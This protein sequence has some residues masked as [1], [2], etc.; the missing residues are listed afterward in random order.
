MAPQV[1]N[2]I[3]FEEVLTGAGNTAAES[4]VQPA[5]DGM[6]H[7]IA[8]PTFSG[9]DETNVCTVLHHWVLVQGTKAQSATYLFH[10][11]THSSLL[12]LPPYDASSFRSVVSPNADGKRCAETIRSIFENAKDPNKVIIGVIEQNSP[13]DDFCLSVSMIITVTLLPL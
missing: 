12:P 5:A 4:P 3:A 1:H 2:G 6:E 13:E 7:F 9:K 10:I 8:I 11:F